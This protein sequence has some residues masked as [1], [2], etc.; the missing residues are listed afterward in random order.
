MKAIG[1]LIFTDSIKDDSVKKLFFEIMR[2][3]YRGSSPQKYFSFI[4]VRR[5]IYGKDKS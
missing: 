5:I 3:I 1:E 2:S 4:I